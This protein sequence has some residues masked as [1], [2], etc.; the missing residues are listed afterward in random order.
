M[1]Q[2]G[3]MDLRA[4]WRVVAMVCGISVC[5]SDRRPGLVASQFCYMLYITIIQNTRLQVKTAPKNERKIRREKNL[6]DLVLCISYKQQTS[7]EKMK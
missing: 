6:A 2:A 4:F 5:H 1:P 3:K 7:S